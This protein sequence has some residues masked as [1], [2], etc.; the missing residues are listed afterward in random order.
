M[1][2]GIITNEYSKEGGGLSFSCL[3]FH[4]LLEDLGHEVFLIYSKIQN[5]LI[6]QGGYNNRLG[7][8]IVWE[9]KLKRDSEKEMSDFSNYFNN[10]EIFHHYYYCYYILDLLEILLLFFFFLFI[11]F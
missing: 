4:R 10:L 6:I 5:S 8:D 7:K 2:I 3:Q 11:E 1:K 9:E